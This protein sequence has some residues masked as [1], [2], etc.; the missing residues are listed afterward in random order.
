MLATGCER[1][2][3]P[4]ATDTTV[5]QPAPVVPDTVVPAPRRTTWDSTAG[6]ALFV[7]APTGA[8][9]GTLVVI[10]DADSGEV[11][12]DSTF[13]VRTLRNL[14]VEMFTRSGLV[15]QGQVGQVA[16]HSDT[17][18]CALWPTVT[19]TN[20]PATS[21]SWAIGFQRGRARAIP[22][23]SI[24]SLASQDSAR[25]AAD[26]TRIASALP[27]DTAAALRGIPFSVQSA[28]RLALTP[29]D[30]A[31]V[32]HIIRKLPIEAN[33]LQEH[34]FLIAERDSSGSRWRPAYFERTS[35]SEE[36]VETTDALA[37]VEL[38]AGRRPTVI[39]ERSGDAVRAFSILERTA[40]GRWRVRWTSVYTGC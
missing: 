23:D 3:Q 34:I 18:S 4:P 17:S 15:G 35:G 1:P 5:A 16:E 2:P 30:T 26:L 24:E 29:R 38:G 7:H 10:P 20:V 21:S 12:T 36:S 14:T 11:P 13:D 25:L 39:L 22:V 31:I 28:Y 40:P 6:P 32:A 19:L 8:S 27:N 9:G 33:P 37:A